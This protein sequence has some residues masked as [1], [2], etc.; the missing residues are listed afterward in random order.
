MIKGINGEYFRTSW[1]HRTR[2]NLGSSPNGSIIR[3]F[4]SWAFP[5]VAAIELISNVLRKEDVTVVLSVGSG[6]GLWERLLELKGLEVKATDA[7]PPER[8]WLK[9]EKATSVEAVKAFPAPCLMCVWPHFLG[10]CLRDCLV[11]FDG[12]YVLYV[13][14]GEEGCTDDGS[15]DVLRN[16]GEWEEVMRTNGN[17]YF[18]LHDDAFLL[19]FIAETRS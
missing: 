14:E 2:C 18:G 1:R 17:T 8:S 10:S 11:V 13:G 3:D 9:C 4:A 6:A 15:V 16:S 7:A 5:S 12:D 19:F